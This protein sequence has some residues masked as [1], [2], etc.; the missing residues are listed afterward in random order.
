MTKRAGVSM[1]K[2]TWMAMIKRAGVTMIKPAGEVTMTN[3]ARVTMTKPAGE[4]TMTNRARVTMTKRAGGTITK[5]AAADLTGH[6]TVTI[7][8]ASRLAA[9]RKSGEDGF[10]TLLQ[11]GNQ[12]QMVWGLLQHGNQL[13][14][15]WGSTAVSCRWCW[16]KGGVGAS[17][18][19]QCPTQA[20]C[21]HTTPTKTS[22]ALTPG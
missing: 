1:T 20:Q 21:K 16:G 12:L 14:M 10:E 22:D 9:A 8:T 13:Q 15:V 3:R 5:R 2:Y 17:Y 19:P 11:Y 6:C 18:D 4:V 7:A